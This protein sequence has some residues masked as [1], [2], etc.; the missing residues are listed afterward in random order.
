LIVS[1]DGSNNAHV[2]EFIDA[3]NGNIDAN[4]LS[5]VVTLNNVNA[6]TLTADNFI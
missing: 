4:E 2:F 3:N 6:D 5:L 1:Y